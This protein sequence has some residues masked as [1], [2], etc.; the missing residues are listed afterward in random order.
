MVPVEQSR[1]LVAALE[2]AGV[3]ASYI[4]LEEADHFT[5]A[6]WTRTGP[7]VLAFLDRHLDQD[8]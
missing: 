5:V 1:L 6:D 3:E 7:L 2:D 8:R 4:E